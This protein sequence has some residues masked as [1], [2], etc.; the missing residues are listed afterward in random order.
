MVSS[1]RSSSDLFGYTL[2]KIREIYF[3]IYIN[4][5]LGGDENVYVIFCSYFQNIFEYLYIGKIFPK[6]FIY[7]KIFIPVKNTSKPIR[8]QQAY[9]KKKIFS[10][11]KIRNS[12]NYIDDYAHSYCGEDF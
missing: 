5:F 10:C 9:N 4:Q 1:E 6:I 11:E 2:L 12:G 7:L 8:P 3:F